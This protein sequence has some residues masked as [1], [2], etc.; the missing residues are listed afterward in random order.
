MSRKLTVLSQGMIIGAGISG[1]ITT[2]IVL[3]PK[4]VLKMVK[5]GM[6]VYEHNPYNISEKVKV[7]PQNINF[8]SFDMATGIKSKNKKADAIEKMNGMKV[9]VLHREEAEKTHVFEEPSNKSKNNKDNKVNKP[10]NF[11]KN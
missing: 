10:D 8:I 5:S 7:T 11:E 4:D 3:D 1:P 6:T 2:P 9:G